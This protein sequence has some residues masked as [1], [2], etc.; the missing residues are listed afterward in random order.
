MDYIDLYRQFIIC[1]IAETESM[2][3]LWLCRQRRW[4]QEQIE[5]AEYF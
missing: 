2:K 3:L 4:G 5:R 1:A